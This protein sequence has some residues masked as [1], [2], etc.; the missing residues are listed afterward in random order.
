[1]ESTAPPD[2]AD[3]QT[4]RRRLRL[5]GERRWASA[6][7]LGAASLLLTAGTTYL[8]VVI[9]LERADLAAGPP[10]DLFGNTFV[11]IGALFVAALGAIVGF[12]FGVAVLPA[13][14]LKFLGW[15]RPIQTGLTIVALEIA[16]VP[17][18]VLLVFWLADEPFS[19]TA[20][21]ACFG[22]IGGVVPALARLLATSEG[23]PSGQVR[24]A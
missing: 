24:S 3:E 14:L 13:A 2:T 20:L 4:L 5:L 9:A 8:G 23:P 16:T 17:V 22:L 10:D 1:M 7:V 12:S 21:V 15:S 6:L 18:L 11:L 19:T